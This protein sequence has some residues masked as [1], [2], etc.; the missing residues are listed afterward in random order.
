MRKTEKEKI[1]RE[2]SEF[3]GDL[4]RWL[5]KWFPREAREIRSTLNGKFIELQEKLKF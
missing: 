1:E 4:E 5:T 2:I 3:H